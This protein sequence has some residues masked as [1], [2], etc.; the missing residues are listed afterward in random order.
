MRISQRKRHHMYYALIRQAAKKYRIPF[1]RLLW[2][3]REEA[4]EA[5]GRLHF[6]FL[7]SGLDR[8][9]F[10]RTTCFWLMDRW[11]QLGGGMARVTMYEPPLKIGRAHV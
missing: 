9:L 5:T 6:H 1:S 8:R 7:L 11:E 2:A 3:L 10:N 4:G